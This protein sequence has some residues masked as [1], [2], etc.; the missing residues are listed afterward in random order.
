MATETKDQEIAR[1]RAQN[2]ELA[3]SNDRLALIAESVRLKRGAI[4]RI[5]RMLREEPPMES[6]TVR[7]HLRCAIT[8]ITGNR[9]GREAHLVAR[10]AD[11]LLH[12][13]GEPGAWETDQSRS[14]APQEDRADG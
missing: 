2:R 3:A 12:E 6:R 9:G 11:A 14:G 4:G 7:D 1:L 13:R 5:S 8:D 10:L